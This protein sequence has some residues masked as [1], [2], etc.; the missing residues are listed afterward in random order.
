VLRGDGSVIPRLYAAG[1]AGQGGVLLAGNGH[2]ICWAVTSGR[3]A[4][5]FAAAT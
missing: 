2:H 4:G 1:A 5:R 3:R